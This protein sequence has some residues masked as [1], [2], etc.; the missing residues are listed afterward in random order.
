MSDLLSTLSSRCSSISLH[1][2]VHTNRSNEKLHSVNL[3][4]PISKVKS[5]PVYKHNYRIPSV[6]LENALARLPDKNAQWECLIEAIND[7]K[8]LSVHHPEILLPKANEAT[9][10]GTGYIKNILNDFKI[11]NLW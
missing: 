4:L 11:T 8:D 6:K 1:E 3:T 5:D 7:V 9:A 10:L 2:K